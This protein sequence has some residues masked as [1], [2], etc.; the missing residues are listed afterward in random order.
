MAV[1]D[2]QVGRINFLARKAKAEGLT[3]EERQEQIELRQAYV[4]AVR[5]NLTGILES[6]KVVDVD[7]EV[8]VVAV[9]LD[10]TTGEVEAVFM[11]SESQIEVELPPREPGADGAS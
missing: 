5:E 11:E 10:G 1:N 7:H 9:E 8:D 3:L 6:I 4:A 2:E